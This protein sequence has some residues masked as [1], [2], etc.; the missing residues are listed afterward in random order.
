MLYSYRGDIQF[1][2]Q[3]KIGDDIVQQDNTVKF[4]GA[5]LDDKL[6]F[7]PHVNYISIKI[8]RSVGI[9]YKLRDLFPI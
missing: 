3:V 6:T 1:P 5:M 7:Y 4:L 9:L 8:S 2:D